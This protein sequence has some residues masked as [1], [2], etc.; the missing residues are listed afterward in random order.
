MTTASSISTPLVLD[1]TALVTGA[2]SGIGR[3]TAIRLAARGHRV[4]V[5]GRS[6]AR[7]TEIV[8]GI[9]AAGGRAEA[10][11]AD[12]GDAGQVLHLA[13]AALQAGQGRV[14][15]LVNHA[16]TYPTLPGTTAGAT[17]EAIDAAF[18]TNVRAPYLLMRELTPGMAERGRGT[19]VNLI[20][21]AASAGMPGLGL[22]GA[23]KA[24][25]AQLTRAWAAEFGPKGVRVNAVSPGP[26]STEGTA[27][28]GDFILHLASQAPAGRVAAPEE[29]AAAIDFLV[30]DDASFIHGVVL[31]VDGGRLAV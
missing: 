3:A 5:A 14:D 22:Y 17:A 4:V 29:I 28:F 20:S 13:R 9:R 18:A 30:S 2:T 19:V 21:T 24:A 8:E 12:L 6:S 26:T 16:A 31:P 1:S 15:V 11:T 23:T 25:L 10:V 7:A 27:Q